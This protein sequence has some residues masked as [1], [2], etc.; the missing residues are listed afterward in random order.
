V[1][2]DQIFDVLQAQKNKTGNGYASEWK[3]T[4]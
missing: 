2:A 1:A 4:A 3:K